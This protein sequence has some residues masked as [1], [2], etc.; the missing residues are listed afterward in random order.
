MREKGGA[1][2]KGRGYIGRD[3]ERSRGE[4]RERG[5]RGNSQ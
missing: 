3:R 2:E 4:E 5:K 1:E